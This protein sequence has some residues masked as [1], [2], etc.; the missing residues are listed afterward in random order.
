MLTKRSVVVALFVV[1]AVSAGAREFKSAVTGRLD[2]E[3]MRIDMDLRVDIAEA[4]IKLPSGRM[5]AEEALLSSYLDTARPF[6]LSIRLDSSDALGDLVASGE[7]PVSIIDALAMQAA[8]KP[9]AYSHDFGS[10]RSSYTIDMKDSGAWLLRRMRTVLRQ[11]AIV[12]PAQPPRLIDPTPV[13]AYTGIIIIADGELPVHGQKRSAELVPCLF[14]KIWDTE[15]NLIYDKSMP[16]LD[17]DFSMV[18]YAAV[19][20]IFQSSPS[21]LSTELRQAVGDRPLRIIARG[22]FGIA[23]TDPVIDRT[24]ALAILSSDTN[25]QLLGEGRIVFIAPKDALI[26]EF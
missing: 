7:I 25:R 5:R 11:T 10:I 21:G 1:V 12:Q 2:W 3:R 4:G 14:P 17:T 6:I 8:H 9:S 13:A 26:R 22:L 24:D 15:M 18:H 20:S 16:E 19:D 23:P